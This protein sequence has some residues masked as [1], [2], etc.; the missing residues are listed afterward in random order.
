MRVTVAKVRARLFGRPSRR[1]Q[2]GARSNGT[3][4]KLLRLD[5]P[6]RIAGVII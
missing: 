3:R 6:L 1:H 2:R 5:A 4:A